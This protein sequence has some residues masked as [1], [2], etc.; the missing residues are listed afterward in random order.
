ME[1]RGV[2][3]AEAGRLGTPPLL[4]VADATGGIVVR[5]PDGVDAPARGAVLVIRGPIADPYGQIELRPKA[6]GV[7][8]DGSAPLPA[9]TPLAA[10]LGEDSEG[11]LA[12]VA[13]TV[14]TKP[15]KATSGDISFTFGTTSGAS[16]RVMADTSSGID[17]ATIRVGAAGRIVGVVGQ[18]ASRKGA[19]D[20]YRLWLRDPRDLA[21]VGPTMPTAPPAPGQSPHP[22]SGP[23]TVSLPIAAAL[24]QDGRA[25][26]IAGVVTAGGTLLDATGRRV[27]VQD[28]TAAVEVLVPTGVAAPPVGERVRVHGT[29][30]TAYGAPRLRAEQVERLGRSALPAPL[31]IRGSLQAVHAWRLVRI[32]GRI[33]DVRKLG[34]R[35]R[36]ELAIGGS[37]LLVVG[38][39]GAR[40]PIGTM[41]EGRTAAVIGIVRPAHPTA[42][43]RRATILPRSGADVTVAQA[44]G[45][46]PATGGSPAATARPVDPGAA[47]GGTSLATALP[48]V[49]P[50]ADL[51]DLAAVVGTNVRVGG[52]VVDLTEDGFT[53]DD[54][55]AVGRIVLRGEAA[56]L[57]GLIEPGDAVNVIGRVTL[58]TTPDDLAV[59]VED[60][61]SIV[62]GSTAREA[63]GS[64][65]LAG[66]PLPSP[67]SGAPVA[68]SGASRTAGLGDGSG[69]P[70]GIG[71]LS[72]LGVGLASVAVTVLRRRHLRR[73]LDSRLAVRLATF[74]GPSDGMDPG[75]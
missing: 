72:L 45:G 26:T 74:V 47:P 61:A 69:L 52:L 19:L 51:A 35:W 37:R 55:T 62:L 42:T 68:S 39:P 56:G 22:S 58:G 7:R 70:G 1:V 75:R 16:I 73:L 36:A 44:A 66:S 10:Q 23:A 3:I 28:A 43:D 57:L 24:R 54:G 21:L 6:D 32:D 67:A 38:Q 59:V 8:P 49:V 65:G 40:I 11:R 27:V 53:L 18:R 12:T 34:D 20:G 63:G 60:A 33:D 41:V 50:D 4:A 25:V 30:G 13:G 9:A 17:P 64:V 15:V 31:A 48:A 5:L 14:E 29:M 71:L 46:V 2:V